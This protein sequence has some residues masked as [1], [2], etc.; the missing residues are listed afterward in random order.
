ME[1]K[2]AKVSGRPD[3]QI[4]SKVIRDEWIVVS[5]AEANDAAIRFV[6]DEV[7]RRT[8]AAS[9]NHK[10]VGY[11]YCLLIQLLGKVCD[12]SLDSRKLQRGKSNDS[13]AWDAR[14]LGSKVVAPF[15]LEQEAVLGTS[16]DPYV[17]NPMRIPAM[18]KDDASKD[19]LPG[20]NAM[21][22]LLEKVESSHDP[23]FTRA[24]FR[25]VLLEVLRRQRALKFTY[26]IPLRVSLEETLSLMRE[27]LMEKSGGDRALTLAAALFDSM[28]IHFGLF[29]QVKRCAINAADAAVNQLADLECIDGD[30]KLVMAV[31]V[32]DRRLSLSD[33]EGTLQKAKQ[34]V[35]SEIF[36]TAPGLESGSTAAIGDR[37]RRSYTSGQNLYV[38]DLLELSRTVLAIGGE[39]IRLTFLTHVGRNLDN[40]NVQPRHR[41]AWQGL[42]SKL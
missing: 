27:F 22:S 15:V 2:A 39:S 41:Q 18:V 42:L 1:K 6:T 4:A 14:S 9:I 21:V 35:V 24:L 34:R 26:S 36:F 11:R 3:R 5:E 8:I 10:Q 12:P 25:Q 38:F 29:K 13:T 19:D 37:I 7:L 31:E 32:K 23:E 40:W 28:G 16:R 17:G 30:G 33:I 20:W